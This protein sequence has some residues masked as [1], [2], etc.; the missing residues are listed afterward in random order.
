MTSNPF[1]SEDRGKKDSSQ[2]QPDE[3]QRS[4]QSDLLQRAI[5]EISSLAAVPQPGTSQEEEGGFITVRRGRRKRNE[6]LYPSEK[7]MT[8]AEKLLDTPE[9]QMQE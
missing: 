2:L 4:E 6:F 5:D 1:Y 3:G 9:D 7:E 8:E